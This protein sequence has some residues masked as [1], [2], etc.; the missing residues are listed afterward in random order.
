M[1][2]GAGQDLGSEWL[3]QLGE[4]GIE[5]SKEWQKQAA[6]VVEPTTPE[7]P[8]YTRAGQKVGEVVGGIA[9]VVAGTVVAPEAVAP[10]LLGG[11]LFSGAMGSMAQRAD[12][13]GQDFEAMPA[14][15]AAGLETATNYL[16]LGSLGP[17]KNTLKNSFLKEFSAEGAGKY[18]DDLVKAEGYTAAEKAVGSSLG[19]IAKETGLN[20]AGIS[21]GNVASSIIERAQ[22]GDDLTSDNALDEYWSGIESGLIGGGMFG[23]VQGMAR[24]GAKEAAVERAGAEM[25]EAAPHPREGEETVG[26]A[27]P[28]T[29]PE[30]TPPNEEGAQFPPPEG[31]NWYDQLGLN[32][33]SKTYHQLKQ[34]DFE[35]PEDHPHIKELIDKHSGYTDSASVENLYKHLEGV[36]TTAAEEQKRGFG[37]KLGYDTGTIYTD[38]LGRRGQFLSA[39]QNADM[40]EPV[41]TGDTPKVLEALRKSQNP[42]TRWLAHKARN[43]PNLRIW[44]DDA[45]IRDLEKRD[46]YRPGSVGGY[47]NGADYGIRIASK[48]N[49]SEH[50]VAHELMHANVYHAIRNPTAPQRPSVNALHTLF[51]TVKGHPLL[52]AQIP[53]RT[54]GGKE[55]GIKNVDEFVSEGL[56]NPEFQYKLSRIKYENT[57]AWGKFT[58]A[59]ANLLGLKKDN[60]F[61]ELMTHTENLMPKKGVT[62]TPFKKIIASRLPEEVSRADQIKETTKLDVGRGPQPVI[63]Q[64]GE[65]APIRGEGVREGRPEGR[66][67]EKEIE[68]E[69]VK[70]PTT[71]STG[72][73]I[74]TTAEG[75]ENFWKNF[76]DTKA[77]D[78][79]GRPVVVYHGTDKDFS[80]FRGGRADFGIHLGTEGQANER[81]SRKGA[82]SARMIAAYLNIKN[83][84]RLDDPGVWDKHEIKWQLGAKFP[85][86]VA[87]IKELQNF[88]SIKKYLKSKGYDGIVY[89]NRGEIPGLAEKEA[90][91]DWDATI[92]MRQNPKYWEDS[93]IALDS[94]QIKS[95]TD[96][97]G[98][99]DTTKPEIQAAQAIEPPTAAQPRT[100]RRPAQ[101]SEPTPPR[102]D[103]EE[104][105]PDAGYAV[106]RGVVK[107]KAAD[108]RNIIQKMKDWYHEQNENVYGAQIRVRAHLVSR[109]APW[110]DA[111][112]NKEWADQEGK[113]RADYM[114]SKYQ[115]IFNTV[116][117]GYDQGVG[118]VGPDGTVVIRPEDR[119]ALGKIMDRVD[120]LK[121]FKNSREVVGFVL[122]ALRGETLMQ[123]DEAAREH[124]ADLRESANKAEAASEKAT[125]RNDIIKEQ[126]RADAL[127]AEATRLE[128]VHGKVEGAGREKRITRE[129]VR[130]A[131]ALLARHADVKDIV[132]DVHDLN[133]SLVDLWEQAELISK[134]TADKWRDNPAYVPLYKSE[135]DLLTDPSKY[136]NM[137]GKGTKSVAEIDKL[138]GG[139]HDV[140]IFENLQK[141][142]AFMTMGAAQNLLRMNAS[143]QL[144]TIGAMKKISKADAANNPLAVMFKQHDENGKAV[145]QYYEANDPLT[146]EAFQAAQPLV[147][148]L[149]TKILRPTT[150]FFRKVTLMNP[151]FWF[152]QLV[153]DPIHASLVADT[154][155]ITPF[156]SAAAMAKILAG[157]S[158]TYKKLQ[159]EGVVGAIEQ[160]KDA[161]QFAESFGK[162]RGRIGKALD[163][164]EHIHESSDAAT[165]VVV[166]DSAYAR[167]KKR[168][169]SDEKAH[170]YA[171]N[172]AREV[173]NFSNMGKSQA[174]QVIR[175]SVPFFSAT[176]NSLDVVARAATGHGLSPA[177]KAKAKQLF[178]TRALGLATLSVGYAL[179][180]QDDKD[181]QKLQNTN[182]WMKNYLFPNPLE[183]GTFIK[184]PI[185][186]EIGYFTKV[187][188]ELWVRMAS[189]TLTTKEAGRAAREGFLST[190]PPVPLPLL[191]R[192]PLETIMNYD[193]FT[194][195]PIERLGQENLPVEE[196]GRREA[197]EIS[198]FISR[199]L[200]LSKAGLS[201]AKV[202][203]LARG[204]MTE[205]WGVTT[206]LSDAYLHKDNPRAT[207]SLAESV[208]LAHGLFTKP[209]TDRLV[210][211]FYEAEETAKQRRTAMSGDVKSGRL[212]EFKEALQDPKKRA[213]YAAAPGLR[214]IA[215]SMASLRH[216]MDNINDN[217]KL[218]KEQ[219]TA[220]IAKLK[221]NYNNLAARGATI[222]NRL[223]LD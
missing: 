139:V 189:G 28:E 68:V 205:L 96:N 188:P 135:E 178:Y 62:Q 25:R 157:K 79:A 155:I 176:M 41:K 95:A 1:V 128:A 38:N 114:G 129:D 132:N 202:E 24:K 9:P 44:E 187:L 162:E 13:K 220:E 145:E 169:M 130:R 6:E 159:R 168:G 161:K 47:Y 212:Q 177:E 71:D 93:Y 181:Y 191:L 92:E 197:S 108:S 137:L 217:P 105:D 117:T 31:V 173:I 89:K 134:E 133:R 61:M 32:N 55:Y 98:K 172:Q 184:V 186:F 207:R 27:P 138:L 74:H 110:T 14:L 190:L 86:D 198:K 143:H 77:V 8:W 66:A 3:Q 131:R 183:K 203:H 53:G 195:R 73:P 17:L 83:P 100:E 37:E 94:K 26:E 84:L 170:T 218:T 160:F 150:S 34:L 149:F 82:E 87:T 210:N 208:P 33:R 102:R 7:D 222:S 204:V 88:G 50:V 19:N 200:G 167:A 107:T 16:T 5:K 213:M 78:E 54:R 152:K 18:I 151:V 97:V 63:R 126:R 113:L 147:H 40:A 215:D 39:R 45:A 196:R 29:P 42:V 52:Q 123:E 206:L 214:K 15:P 35:N 193:M 216:R 21:L 43:L 142:Y 140:N 60:A 146:F 192:T 30:P 46:R 154:G 65:G 22:A 180:M 219:K 90:A 163:K 165:R 115:Q 221:Q 158:D 67:L 36:D 166:Y 182:D 20:A 10:A 56:S 111:L 12:E 99:F 69:G 179:T 118:V 85:E 106:S 120:G 112:K 127:R 174:M 119:L 164:L 72:A 211:T 58:S 70:R 104:T 125:N 2:Q 4:K 141:H 91:K 103:T 109:Y 185:P 144:T 48:N 209:D 64:E 76:K 57:T 49:A 116:R 156:H 201:P 136:V 51:D 75:V 153:R 171:T 199:D 124:I 175:A 122:R 23:P 148:P 80:V 11:T 81:L 194:G 59:V 101:T 121:Q 223:G